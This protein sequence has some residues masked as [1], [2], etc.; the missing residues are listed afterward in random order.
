MANRPVFINSENSPFCTISNINFTYYSGFA[1]VQKQKSIASLHD[2]FSNAF[3]TKKILE[4]SS[5]SNSELGVNLSAFNL[6]IN[7][8]NKKFSVESAFQGS[9]VFELGGPYSDLIGKDSKIAKKDLRLKNSGRIIGF[10]YF[11]RVFPTQPLDYFY[12]WLYINALSLNKDLCEKI[13]EYDAFT[14][15]EFNPSK[16]INCQARACAIFVG[17]KRSNK[18]EKAL[19]SEKDFLNIVYP[20][21]DDYFQ[22]KF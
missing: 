6:M 21:Q 2:N 11:G 10:N 15:I 8:K 3:P 12:N 22:L 1:T 17:L 4:I 13:I 7:S 20:N 19:S 16:S 18:L 14:D 5:K 9:K